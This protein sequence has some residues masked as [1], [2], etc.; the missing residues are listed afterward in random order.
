MVNSTLDDKEGVSNRIVINGI[1]NV[2][3]NRVGE[4]QLVY[5]VSDT[6][7]NRSEAQTLTLHVIE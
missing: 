4:Y 1:G 7:G 3:T 6:D 5:S 2:N